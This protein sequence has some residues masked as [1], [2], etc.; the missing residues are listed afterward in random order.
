MGFSQFSNDL[1]CGEHAIAS[2]LSPSNMH[3][4]W[5]NARF[6]AVWTNEIKTGE[7]KKYTSIGHWY[8]IKLS[9]PLF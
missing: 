2:K 7:N 4:L 5:M 1:T 9:V 8:E 3:N 6:S